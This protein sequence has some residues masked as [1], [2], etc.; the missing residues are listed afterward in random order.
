MKRL[1]AVSIGTLLF[2]GP[3]LA[4]VQAAD[5]NS[6]SSH[7]VQAKK[8]K[9]NCTPGYKPCLPRAS[10]YDCYGGTGN[11]PKYTGKVK[12]KGRD[13]YGLD[14]DGDGIGCETVSFWMD[15]VRYADIY[16]LL[17]DGSTKKVGKKR[18]RKPKNY[19]EF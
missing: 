19:V 12:V 10:D 15:L 6:T 1:T 17:P 14:S 5:A 2:L 13:I 9:K 18:G 4:A 16:D 11:G 7:A 8:K 3:S